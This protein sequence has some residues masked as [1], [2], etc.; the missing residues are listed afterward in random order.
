VGRL[1]ELFTDG[2]PTVCMSLYVSPHAMAVVEALRVA[3]STGLPVDVT[4]IAEAVGSDITNVVRRAVAEDRF[5]AAA[6]VLAT[7]L[8]HD[9]CVA[10]SRFTKDLIVSAAAD[11][12]VRHGSRFAERCERQVHISYPAIDSGPYLDLDPSL[13]AGALARRGLERSGYVLFLSRLAR[14]KGVEELIAGYARSEA[15]RRTRLVIAGDGPQAD[16]LRALTASSSVADR[17]T[18]LDDVDD[19]E[20]PY[21]MHGCAAYVLPS[22]PRPEFVETFGIA[23]AEKMMAGGG[24]VITTDAGG[25]SETVGGCALIVPVEDPEAIAAA[26][27]WAVTMPEEA[28]RALEARAREHALQFDRALIFDR[29]MGRLPRPAALRADE[30]LVDAA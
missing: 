11:L 8:E 9:L 20:K 23:L 27:D 12:D 19:A 30:N 7:Y 6:H 4:I 14:A 22:K 17:I 29:L 15:R 25:I 16:E 28:R 1:V 24:P 2:V 18:F 21:L 3:R 5:G 26:L 10:V 13:L